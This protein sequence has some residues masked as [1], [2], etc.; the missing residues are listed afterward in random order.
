MF[1]MRYWFSIKYT[2][3][4]HKYPYMISFSL[5]LESQFY[6]KFRI[7]YQEVVVVENTIFSMEWYEN[8]RCGMIVHE[9]TIYRIRN[10]FKLLHVE[11]VLVVLKFL[12]T[13]NLSVLLLFFF[14]K[15]LHFKNIRIIHKTQAKWILNTKFLIKTRVLC[16]T[17]TK[18]V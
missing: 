4:G 17:F 11:G 18:V 13:V 10:I 9:T 16:A 14:L 7:F 3:L 5:T 6:G 1:T 8:W 12:Y 15:K 2:S